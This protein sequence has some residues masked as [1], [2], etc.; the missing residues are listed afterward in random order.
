MA[1]LIE[2]ALE[3]RN[4]AI[5]DPKEQDAGV[6]PLFTS[7]GYSL[8]FARVATPRSNSCPYLVAF[9][10]HVGH[11]DVMPL[12]GRIDPTHSILGLLGNLGC[13]YFIECT[14]ILCIRGFPD[15]KSSA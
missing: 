10:N 8:P 7:G 3:L 9:S 2:E 6:S 4:L 13:R 12:V 11:L 1:K 14:F 15:P 5:S